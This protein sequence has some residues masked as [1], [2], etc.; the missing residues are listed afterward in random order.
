VQ[1][2]GFLKKLTSLCPDIDYRFLW[3]GGV[4][5]GGALFML[6]YEYFY[7][8]TDV[9]M[10]LNFTEQ[11]K[12]SILNKCRVKFFPNLIPKTKD[13]QTTMVFHTYYTAELDQ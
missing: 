7:I 6:L 12:G 9:T 8:A 10:L 2:T 5:G 11:I 1:S 13:S 3:G 4:P